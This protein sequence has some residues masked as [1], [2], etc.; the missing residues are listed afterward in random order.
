MNIKLFSLVAK[1]ARN[2]EVCV[3]STENMGIKTEFSIYETN[4]QIEQQHQR[5][6]SIVTCLI[7]HET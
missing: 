6:V 7:M 4:I 5:P 2:R 1:T 3:F